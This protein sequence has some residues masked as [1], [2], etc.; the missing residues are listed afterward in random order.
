MTALLGTGIGARAGS[1]AVSEPFQS[2]LPGSGRSRRRRAGQV[3]VDAARVAGP[4]WAG[5]VAVHL[6]PETE[7][8]TCVRLFF[9]PVWLGCSW[10]LDEVKKAYPDLQNQAG[11]PS[12]EGVNLTAAAGNASAKYRISIVNGKVFTLQLVATLDDCTI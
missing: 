3:R 7:C 5:G 2:G 12:G 11:D 8:L 10:C 4:L 9:S 6:G 1:S